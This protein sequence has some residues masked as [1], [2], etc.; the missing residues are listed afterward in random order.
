[1][2]N[3]FCIECFTREKRKQDLP[4]R[5]D[6]SSIIKKKATIH[7]KDPLELYSVFKPIGKGASASVFLVMNKETGLKYA[8]KV[9]QLT[10]EFNKD[11]AVNEIGL[12]QMTN[13][14]NIVK[15]IEAYEIFEY[16]PNSK[17]C[18]I[19]ELM[20][21]SLFSLVKLNFKFSEQ[22]IAYVCREV[23]KGTECLH[24]FGRIHRDIKTDNILFNEAGEVKITDFGFTAQLTAETACRTT[25]VGTPSYM[26]PEIIDGEGYD[27]KVDIWA[28][29]IV[30]YELAEGKVPV[31]GSN[32]LEILT[33]TSNSPSPHLSQQQVWSQE[34][35]EFL[36]RCFEKRPDRRVTSKD[37]L[38]NEFLQCASKELLQSMIR[39]YISTT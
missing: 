34:F 23:L 36:A 28:L 6:F 5:K 31:Q 38:R 13:H 33:T 2:R 25:I 18:L 19:I 22:V 11:R 37:L 24:S 4:K 35:H 20:T 29:G 9:I 10:S 26:A 3:R 16:L 21:E 17:I 39:E 8:M 32:N 14:E 1:M 30:A 12:M 7:K 15:I 27:D